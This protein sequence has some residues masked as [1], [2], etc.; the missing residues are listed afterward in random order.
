MTWQE[1]DN[2]TVNSQ[3]RSRRIG[4][5]R[6][7]RV[8][9]G[10]I[11]K[12]WLLNRFLH[13][14]IR[15]AERIRVMKRK[16]GGRTDHSSM[17]ILNTSS[18]NAASAQGPA[19]GWWGVEFSGTQSR[20]QR[21]TDLLQLHLMMKGSELSPFK[22][23]EREALIIC[24]EGKPETK[25]WSIIN[26]YLDGTV[27]RCFLSQTSKITVKNQLCSKQEEKA[28]RLNMYIAVRRDHWTKKGCLDCSK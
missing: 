19:S 22:A 23:W 12:W 4:G 16:T 8:Q 27:W 5:W 21:M 7:S 6:W 10:G 15:D 20:S 28:N 1:G 11:M 18:A 25:P 26:K 24:W 17:K 3:R 9:V 14:E 13:L 2:T